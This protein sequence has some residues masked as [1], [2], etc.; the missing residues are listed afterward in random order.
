MTTKKAYRY[1][2]SASYAV[3]EHDVEYLNVDGVTRL[4]RIYQPEGPGPFPM[5]LSIHGGA[6]TDKDHTEYE[7]TST[8]LAATGIV[9]AAIGQRVGKGFPYPVQLQ[10]INYGVRWLKAHASDFNGDPDSVGGIGYS[11]GGHTL[12]LAAMRPT[13]P[14]YSALPLE[15]SSQVDA[16]FAFTI[17]C[18]P[19]IEPYFRYEIAREKGNTDLMEKH[20]IFFQG[21]EAMH[22]STP[23]NIIQSGEKVTL[24]PAM[25]MHG[26]A[27]DVM[28]IE[29][30]ERF[31]AAYNGAGGKAQLVPW[32]GKGHGWARAAGPEADE[33]V[34][35][36]S[37]FIAKQLG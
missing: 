7:S 25:V 11:S 4:V 36:A 9:V 30:S 32:Q 1:D 13:D 14:R 33:F 24:P 35:I 22:E 12:P 23:I 31:V 10:D 3:T 20:H 21:D 18:W 34:K 15:G 16:N 19:V 37:E 28:P 6:W 17:S 2:P 5:L 29:A 26:T 27:D 8:P